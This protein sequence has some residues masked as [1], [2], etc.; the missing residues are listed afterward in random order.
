M[1]VLVETDTGGFWRRIELRPWIFN[2]DQII[3]IAPEAA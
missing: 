3:W 1:Q 2:P